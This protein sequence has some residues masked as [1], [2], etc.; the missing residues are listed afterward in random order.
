[1]ISIEKVGI[2]SVNTLT[3]GK[4]LISVNLKDKRG[5]TV[6]KRLSKTVRNNPS[7]SNVQKSSEVGL[8]IY[9]EASFT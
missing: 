2:S 9:I 1:M 7:Q 5:V 8:Q 4:R 3:R 6:V